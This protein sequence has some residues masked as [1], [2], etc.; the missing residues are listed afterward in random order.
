M[1][2]TA[3]VSPYQLDEPRSN[4]F[5]RIRQ[6]AFEPTIKASQTVRERFLRPSNAT[7]AS[8]FEVM[9]RLADQVVTLEKRLRQ[10]EPTPE[11]M[12]QAQEAVRAVVELEPVVIGRGLAQ[13]LEVQVEQPNCVQV[14]WTVTERS[15]EVAEAIRN[16]EAPIRAAHPGV[17]LVTHLFR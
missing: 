12:L 14:I 8:V 10:Y 17:R 9:D 13:R 7:A 1:N 16:L 5:E 4:W 15:E 3:F 6:M 2:T 11:D